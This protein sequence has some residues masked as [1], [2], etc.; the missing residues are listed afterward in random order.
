MLPADPNSPEKGRGGSQ[1][2][3]WGHG[4]GGMTMLPLPVNPG[5]DRGTLTP[6]LIE[7]PPC[8]RGGFETPQTWISEEL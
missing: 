3:L 1:M 5:E 8:P 4:K 2:Q 6:L 7:V